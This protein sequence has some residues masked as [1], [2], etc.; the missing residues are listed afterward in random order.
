M[1]K[2][3]QEDSL[4]QEFK[5]IRDRLGRL[6]VAQYYNTVKR[7]RQAD[8]WGVVDPVLGTI[9]LKT[10]VEYY[11]D[12]VGDTFGPG[13]HAVG[14]G[15]IR[16]T[17]KM[18]GSTQRIACYNPDKPLFTLTTGQTLVA[19]EIGL[20]HIAGG[21]IFSGDGGWHPITAPNLNSQIVL[22]VVTFF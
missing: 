19:S 10:G 14:A 1:S 22:T 7:I 12:Y 15:T 4:P 6:E 5:N 13:F 2:T 18:G 20:G 8:D 9:E 16:I 3:L 21:A 17:G 11:V